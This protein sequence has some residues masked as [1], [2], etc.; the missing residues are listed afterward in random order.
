MG[1]AAALEADDIEP[2]ERGA[3]AERDGEGND[4]VFDASEA[5]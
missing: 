5:A 3:I 1:K 4:V 2:G